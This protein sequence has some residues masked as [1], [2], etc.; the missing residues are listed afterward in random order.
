MGDNTRSALVFTKVDKEYK[1][2]R[3][4]IASEEQLLSGAIIE[5]A[6]VR[7]SFGPPIPPQYILPIEGAGYAPAIKVLDSVKRGSDDDRQLRKDRLADRDARLDDLLL[8]HIEG[9]EK[10]D[11]LTAGFFYKDKDAREAHLGGASRDS[12]TKALQRLVDTGRLTVK[13]AGVGRSKTYHLTVA[14]T[15]PQPAE[16]RVEG[17]EADY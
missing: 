2:I 10:H 9:R 6:H 8:E 13:D 14:Q 1:G 3:Q 17:E 11:P 12:V 7:S 4:P 15:D 5:I 16:A